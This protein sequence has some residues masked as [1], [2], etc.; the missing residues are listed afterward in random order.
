MIH[1]WDQAL[2]AYVD[3]ELMASQ[4]EAVEAR[5][6]RDAEYS[7]R[8][9]QLLRMRKMIHESMSEPACCGRLMTRLEAETAPRG[10][11]AIPYKPLI[12]V[13]AGLMFLLAS[14][15][16]W[17]SVPPTLAPPETPGWT[18]AERGEEPERNPDAL[19]ETSAVNMRHFG[20]SLKMF[21]NESQGEYLPAELASLYPEYLVDLSILNSPVDEP[22]RVSYELVFAAVPFSDEDIAEI[23]AHVTGREEDPENPAWLRMAAS[24]VPMAIETVEHTDPRG[25]NVLFADGHVQFVTPERFEQIVQPFLDF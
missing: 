13:A 7:R 9:T 19:R 8:Y 22:G 10:P 16:L 6:A 20:L 11:R 4:R 24:E 15:L 21:T 1:D 5:L 17:P 23:Y 18:V 3:G 2:S 14:W 25:R 12:A